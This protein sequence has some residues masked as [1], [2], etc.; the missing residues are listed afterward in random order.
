LF[1]MTVT[2]FIRIPTEWSKTST[3][4]LQCLTYNPYGLSTREDK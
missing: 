2:M 4:V 3:C 1:A